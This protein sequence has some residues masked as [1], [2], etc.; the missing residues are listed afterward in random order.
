LIKAEITLTADWIDRT[1]EV[2]ASLGGLG[3][4]AGVRARVP[5]GE[6]VSV[7]LMGHNIPGGPSLVPVDDSDAPALV[8]AG[9]EPAR[10][11]VLVPYTDFGGTQSLKVTVTIALFDR[12][13]HEWTITEVLPG[14][15]FRQ[16]L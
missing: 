1:H 10:L 2:E 7:V 4:G 9:D 3:G 14:R 5:P 15:L 6:A 12:L 16:Q 13:H 11:E 8:L